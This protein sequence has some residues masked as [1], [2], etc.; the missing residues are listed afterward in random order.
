MS[1]IFPLSL[2]HPVRSMLLFVSF[3]IFVSDSPPF[4]VKQ[5]NWYYVTVQYISLFLKI[6][7]FFYL[8]FSLASG[9]HL[10]PSQCAFGLFYVFEFCISNLLWAW[11]DVSFADN[12]V[13]CFGF[14]FCNCG[15]ILLA[16]LQ[17]HL[18]EACTL[19]WL[20][21]DDIIGRV[22]KIFV[23]YTS[24]EN[25]VPPCKSSWSTSDYFF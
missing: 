22:S 2:K 14:C 15:L 18:E 12:H 9:S 20:D 19:L 7:F 24:R 17:C 16:F 13:F 4:T 25:I 6:Y 8:I 3:W 10:L 11:W 5:R 21:L 1:F 23:G